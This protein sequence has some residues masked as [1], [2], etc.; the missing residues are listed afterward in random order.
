VN[1]H[2]IRA[3]GK[4]PLAGA[5]LII[6]IDD[7][8]PQ[9]DLVRRDRVLEMPGVAGDE[10]A[11]E[12]IFEAARSRLLLLRQAVGERSGRTDNWRAAEKRKDL[13]DHRL[14]IRC[15]QGRAE[16]CPLSRQ[17]IE[18][19]G[20][21]AAVGCILPRF[22]QLWPG[23]EGTDRVPLRVW[24]RHRSRANRVIPESGSSIQ[25]DRYQAF[26]L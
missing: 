11:G 12:S 14:P 16:E 26:D 21:Q 9:Q 3:V 2:G 20:G 19:P 6:R 18:V 24:G 15:W 23:V 5:A 4:K 17:K 10:P 7:P 13:N 25:H 8:D 22:A 1:P